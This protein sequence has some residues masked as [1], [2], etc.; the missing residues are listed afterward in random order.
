MIGYYEQLVEQAPDGLVIHN[1]ERIVAVNAATLRLAG[2]T[3]A[4][5]LVGQPVTSLFERPYLKSVERALC[6]DVVDAD[7]TAFSRE[8]LHGI[9]GL[10]RDVDVSVQLF[11]EAGT[12]TVHLVLHDA[13]GQVAAERLLWEHLETARHAALQKQWRVVAGGT[14]HRLNN[15]MQVVIGFSDELSRS[16]L[17]ASQRRDLAEIKGAA[18]EC[19]EITRRMLQLSGDAPFTPQRTFLDTTTYAIVQELNAK[20]RPDFVR[21]G[22]SSGPVPVVQVD[23]R[24]LHA[25]VGYLVDNA[26]HAVQ[27]H[28]Q[29]QLVVRTT[30]LT[31]ARLS[32]DG[33]VMKDGPYATVMVR[34]SG[35]GIT[36]DVQRRMLDPF[37]STRSAEGAAGLG[38]SAVQGIMRQNAGFLTF[39]SEPG[40]GATFTLWFVVT[41]SHAD[42]GRR[43]PATV[44]SAGTIMVVE[45]HDAARAALRRSLERVGYRVFV[46]RSVD[47]AL[48]LLGC[49]GAPL[50]VVVGSGESVQQQRLYEARDQKWPRLPL[51]VLAPTD[52]V[53]RAHRGEDARAWAVLA[54][55]FSEYELVSAVQALVGRTPSAVKG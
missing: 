31:R 18:D 53:A 34:D 40:K 8:R 5:Q 27:G 24:Q 14:A 49:I 15:A 1:G 54:T 19:A 33:R 13:R 23:P 26:R 9:D 22:F 4:Q 30:T 42:E 45:R 12:P 50:A 16:A 2:A 20:G 41:A 3:H 48:E 35:V 28:G 36:L 51:L 44:V 43:E 7:V 47:E 11:L 39:S 29:I 21:I 32:S 55:P 38:L 6:G 37:F 17:S 52:D 10:V 25:M 46:T